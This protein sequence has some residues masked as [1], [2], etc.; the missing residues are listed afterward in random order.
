MSEYW[1]CLC[2]LTCFF[3]IMTRAYSLL[4]AH[5][6]TFICSHPLTHIHV[7]TSRH[8]G[9]SVRSPY[10]QRKGLAPCERP[11][12]GADAGSSGPLQEGGEV[13][14]NNCWRRL[15]LPWQRCCAVGQ[16]LWWNFQHNEEKEYG[17]K[18]FTAVRLGEMSHVYSL[19]IYV[20][21]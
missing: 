4:T 17:Q 11:S 18:W 20:Y 9:C 7:Q 19:C 1:Q 12:T 14:D 10:L 15:L 3:K 2:Q 21:V 6:N 16:I 13:G 8:T 5:T